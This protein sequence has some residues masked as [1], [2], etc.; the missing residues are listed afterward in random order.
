MFS[1]FSFS[2]ALAIGLSFFIGCTANASL[3]TVDGLIQVSVNIKGGLKHNGKVENLNDCSGY[4]GQGFDECEISHVPT[5]NSPVFATVMGKFDTEKPSDNDFTTD[6]FANDWTFNGTNS[7]EL[8]NANS[9][10]WT[11]SGAAYPGI[12]FWVAKGGNEGFILNWM[13]SQDNV[14]NNN[15]QVGNEFSISCL[16]VSIAVTSGSWAAPNPHNLSH[17]SFYGNK[18]ANNNCAPPPAPVPEPTSIALL[19]LALLGLAA[20]RKIFT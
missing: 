14:T 17:I 10:S 12:S 16:S 1:R 3:T 11:Y 6:S 19:S 4:F 5:I 8:D 2:K 15:C 18:C 9:G 7:N 13:V 20:R